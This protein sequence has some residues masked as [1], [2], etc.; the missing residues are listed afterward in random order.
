MKSLLVTMLLQT[1]IITLP[2]GKD[3]AAIDFTLTGFNVVHAWSQLQ[4]GK[5]M[6]YNVLDDKTAKFIVY[7]HSS[8]VIGKDNKIVVEGYQTASSVKV[9]DVTGASEEAVKVK[10]SNRYNRGF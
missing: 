3:I 10:I 9:T 2:V 4:D 5:V 8:D 7:G 1:L 6:E